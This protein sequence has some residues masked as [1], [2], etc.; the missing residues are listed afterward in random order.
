MICTLLNSV[1][2]NPR[3]RAGRWRVFTT[4]QEV[5]CCQHGGA[6]EWCRWA[7]RCE[8]RLL[9]R[10]LSAVYQ[11]GSEGEG[12]WRVPTAGVSI[13]CLS[14]SQQRTLRPRATMLTILANVF[15]F[16]AKNVYLAAVCVY[17]LRS[18]RRQRRRLNGTCFCTE[19]TSPRW[20]LNPS[21]WVSRHQL[22]VVVYSMWSMCVIAEEVR[23]CPGGHQGQ[24]I[25]WASSCQDVRRVPVKWRQKVRAS[26]GRLD[27]HT[28]CHLVSQT[29]RHSQFKLLLR[30]SYS[31]CLT[32]ASMVSDLLSGPH[33]F[34]RAAIQASSQSDVPLA[35]A[36]PQG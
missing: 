17:F 29:Q 35:S 2:H 20:A 36:Y 28:P 5:V 13:L 15:L 14:V 9:H 21:S 34:H 30:Q 10:Q 8:K 16:Q 19:P 31:M 26:I 18:R 27:Q 33:G 7:V 25:T 11:R 32:Q 22:W 12:R 24:L 4:C 1:S 3:H 6:A 23:G